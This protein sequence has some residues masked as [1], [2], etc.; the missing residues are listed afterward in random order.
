MVEMVEV[1][2]SISQVLAL[3]R[4]TGQIFALLYL[5]AEPLSLNQMSLML[6]TSNGSASMET[7]QLASWRAIR[8]FWIPVDR[9]DY[10]E[11]ILDLGQL[12]LGGGNNFKSKFESSRERLDTLKLKLSKDFQSG[13]FPL[14]Q[15]KIMEGRINV[16]EKVHN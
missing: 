12:I 2:G 8:K 11:V 10:Y 16:L 13:V 7:H 1:G 4:S 9:R 6:G 3:P 5:S 14:N 15:K